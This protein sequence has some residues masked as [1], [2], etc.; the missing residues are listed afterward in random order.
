MISKAD[1]S[2]FTHSPDGQCTPKTAQQS[3]LNDKCSQLRAAKHLAAP[4]WRVAG[5]PAACNSLRLTGA[6]TLRLV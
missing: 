6:S 5:V 3:L 2:K 1:E 4:T